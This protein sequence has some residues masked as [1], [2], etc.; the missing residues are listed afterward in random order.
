MLTQIDVVVIGGGQ[1]GL[2]TAYFLRRAAIAYVVLD[3]QSAPG[4]AWRHT[5][6]SLHLFSPAQW[7]SL[8]GWQM[9]ASKDE[10]P[11]RNE[12][13]DYLAKY[14]ARYQIPIERPVH[15]ESVSRVE[16]GLVVTTDRGQWLAKAVV[17]ATGTWS[18]PYIPSYPGR[19]LFRGRQIHSAEYRNA[20]ELRGQE[21]LVVGGGNSGAQILAEISKVC[22]ATWVTMHEPVF[23]PDDVDGQVLF[24]RATQRWKALRDGRT[25]PVPVGGLGDIVMVPPVQEARTRDVLHARRPF[26]SFDVDGVVWDDGG[27]SRVD[28]VIWCT[29]FRPALHHLEP[30]QIRNVDGVPTTDGTRARDEP[31]LWLVGYGEWCGAA[32][33]TLIGVMRGA[34]DTA[35]EI[36]QLL[37]SARMS[38]APALPMSGGSTP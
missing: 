5:W 19:E 4:G 11:S 17:S 10:Y 22:N 27:H 36:A 15:V 16:E 26:V 35:Q 8:P 25:P 38:A 9:P 13:I 20:E 18:E 31:R 21:V 37:G 29:G 14:E 33:A 32:S 1:A 30:L 24:E 2:A 23:L 7:S 34:R 6:D 28:V 3:D 12:V